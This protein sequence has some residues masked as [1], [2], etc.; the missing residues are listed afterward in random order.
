MKW[1]QVRPQLQSPFLQ[2]VLHVDRVEPSKRHL[3]NRPPFVNSCCLPA[4]W[5][6]SFVSRNLSTHVNH[7]VMSDKLTRLIV[8]F[9]QYKIE[10][11]WWWPLTLRSLDHDDLCFQDLCWN[12]KEWPFW[13]CEKLKMVKLV[14]IRIRMLMR[15]LS[16]SLGQAI[17]RQILVMDR[18]ENR[19]SAALQRWGCTSL[20]IGR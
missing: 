18:A 20:H 14:K 9:Y 3:D 5:E 8:N 6:L 7:I 19:L 2:L 13:K 10:R 17:W 4:L 11:R 16:L 1:I 15:I 12:W